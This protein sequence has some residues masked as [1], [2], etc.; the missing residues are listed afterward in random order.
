MKTYKAIDSLFCKVFKALVA[1]GGVVCAFMMVLSVVNVIARSVFKSPVFGTV[2]LISY[3][4]LLLGAFALAMNEEKDGNAVMTLATDAMKPRLR[5]G[6]GVV[7]NIL[8]TI[9]YGAIAFR[10]FKEVAITFAKATSTS[11]L[12]I[13]FWVINL[14]MAVGYLAAT[15]ALALK[16]SR[17]V[18]YIAAGEETGGKEG[19]E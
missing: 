14:I 10:Y 16:A 13:P 9:F 4:G 5:S 12:H 18:A 3:C 19:A 7:T 15:L 11:T 8:A 17:C 2:E 6:F 1:I